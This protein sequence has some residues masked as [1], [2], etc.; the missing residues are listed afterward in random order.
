MKQFLLAGALVGGVI[1]SASAQDRA[2]EY[3]MWSA[4]RMIDRLTDKMACT[5][6]A[7]DQTRLKVWSPR[8]S[9]ECKANVLKA[10]P[11]LTTIREIAM[12]GDPVAWAKIIDIIHRLEAEI[13]GPLNNLERKNFSFSCL[14][15]SRRSWPSFTNASR[16]FAGGS[17]R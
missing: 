14:Q 13:E 2:A 11:I 3:R 7:C 4:E 12:G 8:L 6:N 17:R 9:D 5:N 16:K 1:S 10:A 15:V